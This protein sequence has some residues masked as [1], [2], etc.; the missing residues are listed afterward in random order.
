M[1]FILVVENLE[2]EREPLPKLEA[3]YILIPD[4]E[5]SIIRLLL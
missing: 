1:S 3:I 5:V 2:K 4:E